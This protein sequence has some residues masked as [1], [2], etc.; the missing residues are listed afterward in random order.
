MAW[1]AFTAIRPPR[2][3]G[4]SRPPVPPEPPARAV[5]CVRTARFDQEGRD[6]DRPHER[7]RHQPLAQ[8]DRPRPRR[9]CRG[10]SP[11]RGSAAGRTRHGPRT[12]PNGTDQCHAHRRP[13]GR[14]APRPPSP[15]VIASAPGNGRTPAPPGRRAEPGRGRRRPT[16]AA[17]IPS[18]SATGRVMIKPAIWSATSRS[19]G[20]PASTTHPHGTRPTSSTAGAQSHAFIAAT[21]G[22][23]GPE[24]P[25]RES[26]DEQAYVH[27]PGRSSPRA[28][29]AGASRRR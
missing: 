7:R 1:I 14:P 2:R 23:P 13:P 29:W 3:R 11:G 22:R 27:C 15:S 16:R 12:G 4:T 17:R 9:A 25:G 19:A 20:R 24:L 26:V 10:S 18:P 8:P 5:A 6:Q 28:R 21:P